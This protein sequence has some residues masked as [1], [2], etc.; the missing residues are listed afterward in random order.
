[1]FINMRKLLLLMIFMAVHLIGHSQNE[2]PEIIFTLNQGKIEVFLWKNYFDDQKLDLVVE[3]QA[4]LMA[5]D[6]RKK[7]SGKTTIFMDLNNHKENINSM[8]QNLYDWTKEFESFAI[9]NNKEG[10]TINIQA[11]D[12]TTHLRVHKSHIHVFF[13]YTD[14]EPRSTMNLHDITEFKKLL[15]EYINKHKIDVTL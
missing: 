7:R 14:D 1:M 5:R 4:L 9:N 6:I 15:I 10:D 12:G 2:K 8:F 11:G 3:C 13:M